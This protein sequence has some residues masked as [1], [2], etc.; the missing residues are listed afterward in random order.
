MLELSVQIIK[1][2]RRM[3]SGKK[4]ITQQYVGGNSNGQQISLNDTHGGSKELRKV[5]FLKI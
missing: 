2:M 4:I 1:A 5:Y 3:Q